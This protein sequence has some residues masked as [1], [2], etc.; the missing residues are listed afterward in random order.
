MSL[1][2]LAVRSIPPHATA[3]FS[4]E[5]LA[6]DVHQTGIEPPNPD[7]EINKR[8]TL[9]QLATFVPTESIT[10]Y[11]A[12]LATA[13]ALRQE[14]PFFTA[15]RM[16]WGGAMLTAILFV[17]MVLTERAKIDM[18]LWRGFP[19]WRLT[20]AIIAFLCWALAV[21]NSPYLSSDS[22]RAVAAFIAIFGSVMLEQIDRLVLSL[23]RSRRQGE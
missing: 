10:I 3:T 5:A 8:S 22:G 12:A 20:A 7:I 14:F 4:S 11:L 15:E 13:S 19:F 21:P 16:Y 2:D 17:I 23:N 18:A 6:S 9:S 1:Y